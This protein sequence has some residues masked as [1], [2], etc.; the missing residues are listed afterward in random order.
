MTSEGRLPLLS[1]K[2]VIN[3]LKRNGFAY[4][5]KR[6]KGSH[7]AMIK[8]GGNGEKRLVVIP[9]RKVIPRGTLL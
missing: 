6:G 9:K 5:P 8:E 3:A 4:A 1:S 2:K 7:V